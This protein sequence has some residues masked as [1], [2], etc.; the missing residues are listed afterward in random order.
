P[1]LSWKISAPS[2]EREQR[3]TAYH[4]LVASSPEKLNRDEADVWDSKTVVSGSSHLIP[5]NGAKLVAGEDYY[6][7]VKIYDG[8]NNASE[9]SAT[10][11]FSMGMLNRSD[12]KGVWIKHPE[13]APEQHTWFRQRLNI[14]GKVA[15]AFVHIASTGYHELYINGQK[16]DERLLAPALARLDKRTLY[17]TYDVAPLLKKGDN[18]VAL[19]YGPGWS[20]YNFFAPNVDQAFLL[21]LNGTTKNGETFSLHSDEKWKCSESYSRNSGGFQFL[22]MG[23]EEVD[24]RLY[25]DNWNTIAF[26]DSRWI[27]PMQTTP[28]K[29]GG[30]PML[31]AQ[32]TDITRIV[33]TIPAQSLIDT[34]PGMW[35]VDMGKN[36]TGFI[37]A[38][39]N[40]LKKGDTVVIKTS[41]RHD[42][43]DEYGQKSFYIARGENGETF[44]NRFNFSAGRYLHFIGLNNPPELSAVKAYAISSAA[45]RTGYFE[46]SDSL[47]NRIYDIDRW[48]Y[49]IC[50]L[51]G[52]TVDCPHR[53]RLGY[54]AEG[55][56]QTTWGLGL[57]C[58]A[59]GA[60]YIKNVRDW[61]DV[62][63]RNG[64][65]HN[66]APQINHMWG[67]PLY[68][69]ANMNIAWEHYLAHGDKRILEQAFGTGKRWLEFL[70]TH[71]ADGM[72]V[73]YDSHGYFIGD[74]LG[75]GHRTE[76]GNTV[77]AL[78][79]NNCAYAMA[80][81]L[82]CRIAELLD[83]DDETA[84]Y[85]ERLA[86]L[87][88]KVH[89]KYYNP[90]VNSYLHGDQVRTSFALYAK[91]FPDSLR[92]AAL[93][94]LEEDMTGAHPY[95]DIGS[96]SRYPY[97][98]TL[99]A[100]P[101]FHEIIANILAKTSSPGYGYILS[102]GETAWTEVWEA[103]EPARIHTSFTG[104]SAWFIK[105]LA[106]IEP[107]IEG[108]GYRIFTIRPNVVKRLD[109]A[110][111]ALESPYGL[112]ESGWKKSGNTVVYEISVPA[113]SEARIYLPA[114]ASGITE[115]GQPL[116]SV[117]S[118]DIVEEKDGYVQIFAKSGKYKLESISNF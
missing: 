69:N 30:E 96:S 91:I 100:E 94:H 95:F 26:D 52:F 76:F 114:P 71:V 42:V 92:P 99:F 73:S 59:S 106:G 15:S 83:R 31:S 67:G 11:R 7:K 17:A 14:D 65:I 75:P 88:A 79:F 51:E 115:N 56:Y 21:Q 107:S 45:Q 38:S 48:T 84:V 86:T 62:Q 16:A 20:R 109:Y 77:E 39:F 81:E 46:C 12:W 60:F 112:I 74:W 68:G 78:F 40:G 89:E 55:A 102:Q 36:F 3:Q 117:Q 29:R 2:G 72:L 53:E 57:P 97:F 13:A 24:G 70:H 22:D 25:S 90:E 82:F 101:R 50:T 63:T 66:T 103:N 44:R 28:L 43:I 47:F 58:F 93:K 9:W 118:L 105:G 98:K 116:A 34:I 110:K 18:L 1:R 8:K 4:I 19:W 54:G 87:R 85:R 111:A 27:H 5:F 35:R 61:S 108:P 113:G 6:W 104:I 64:W 33:E 32:M 41:D 23:G 10:A 49:E 80:L 37:E